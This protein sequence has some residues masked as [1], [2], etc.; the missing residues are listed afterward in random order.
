M[1][2]LFTYSDL[3]TAWRCPR[4]WYYERQGW[5]P[6][7]TPEAMLRGTLVHKAVEA[8]HNKQEIAA[9]LKAVIDEEM[10]HRPVDKREGLTELAMTAYNLFVRYRDIYLG[11]LQVL[12]AEK[13]VTLG[14]KN[15][16]LRVGGTPDLIARHKDKL[17]LI[18]IKTGE[19]SDPEMLDISAQG[20]YYAYLMGQLG[21]EID[22]LYIDHV[23]DKYL[24]RYERPPRLKIGEWFFDDLLAHIAE[25][26]VADNF[27]QPAW[28]CYRCPFL[29]PCR[30]R[31]SNGDDLEI[32]S[33]GSWY[34][35][36]SRMKR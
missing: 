15:K 17:V 5:R 24:T 3:V 29:S 27:P 13:L 9:A 1:S 12:Q 33:N 34:L 26:P 31:D 14:S 7:E 20:D 36:T 35:D 18:E 16:E 2:E 30:V 11:D 10:E 19:K 21:I 4:R 8:W 28:D 6:L 32:L 25:E 23:T 22:L